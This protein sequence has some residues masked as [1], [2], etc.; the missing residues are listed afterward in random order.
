MDFAITPNAQTFEG[1]IT[2]LWRPYTQ[3]AA[4]YQLQVE[5]TCTRSFDVLLLPFL[6]V[7]C[8]SEF[9]G[10]ALVRV[11]ARDLW[12]DPLDGL[13]GWTLGLR[14]QTLRCVRT[15]HLG[16]HQWE[17]DIVHVWHHKYFLKG[18]RTNTVSY[19]TNKW[20]NEVFL[21]SLVVF[22]FYFILIF[23]WNSSWSF[24]SIHSVTWQE[25]TS[26]SPSLG[27]TCRSNL[28]GAE[29]LYLQGG[30]HQ[31]CCGCAFKSIMWSHI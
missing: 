11:G 26:L 27:R 19:Q 20:I 18:N 7:S 31:E 10:K 5:L 1:G 28:G 15:V 17:E 30:G 13:G 4:R 16:V 25:V 14:R 6:Q 24:F 2:S 22:G 9:S 8:T 12:W 3:P 23:T 21:I 29:K